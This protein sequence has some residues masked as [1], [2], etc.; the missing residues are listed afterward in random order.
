MSK[1][2]MG[3]GRFGKAKQKTSEMRR[4]Q[5]MKHPL[6]HAQEFGFFTRP[7]WD[8]KSHNQTC[9]LE[10]PLL[11]Q[12]DK[13]LEETGSSLGGCYQIR[14]VRRWPSLGDGS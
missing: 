6:Y 1:S 14:R 3:K 5:L 7:W 4:G 11:L 8:W 12:E 10:C 2:S 13:G 9:I